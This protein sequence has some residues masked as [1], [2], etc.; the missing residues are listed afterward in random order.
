MTLTT[1]FR[2][3]YGNRLSL[4]S[5][6]CLCCLLICLAG[7]NPPKPAKKTGTGT[8]TKTTGAGE[9][10]PDCHS[11][12]DNAISMLE[13]DRLGISSSLEA[14]VS[15]L[16]DWTYRCCNF[17]EKPPRIT[18]SQKPFLKKYLSEAQLAKMDL[19]RFTE[20]DGTFIRDSQLFNGMV[21]AAIEGRKNDRERITAA[22]YYCMNN[23]DLVPDSKQALPFSPYEACII[24]SATAE[25]RAW[26][27]INLMRQL[28]LDAVLFRPAKP[29]PFKMLVGVFVGNEIY[30]FD[31]VLGLPVPSPAQP[32]DAV[33]I[34]IP[35]TY[36]EVQKTPDLLKKFYGKYSDS[37]FSAEE[38][39]A[40][41]VE[42]IGRSSEWSARMRRLEDSLSRKQ[43]FVLFRNLDPLEGDPGFIGHIQTIGKGILKD[44][45]ILVSE[46]PDQQMDK[47]ESVSGDEAKI[48]SFLKMPFKAPI[49]YEVS[50]KTP[51]AQGLYEAQWGPPTRKLLKTRTT[52]L[53]GNQKAAVKSYVTT[54]LEEHMPVDLAVAPEIRQMH[55]MAGQNAAY[56][57]GIGQFIQGEYA[58][59]SISLDAYLNHRGYVHRTKEG[60]WLAR[61]LSARY[62]R[63]I[64]DAETGKLS[65]AFVTLSEDEKFCPEAMK[66]AF[67]YYSERWK[68]IRDRNKK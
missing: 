7:C 30:L 39:K 26:I 50:A 44:A 46:Y 42:I 45:K 47:A 63:A 65:Y 68:A 23:I 56:F 33:Q 49:P 6:A 1:L 35:A 55:F 27:Y 31:P 5:G 3:S 14:A 17:D 38:L 61:S 8:G 13:P 36:A 52:Q 32:E 54:R 9:E 25:E 53:L 57:I 12:I 19:T 64:A 62:H 24:G 18:D 22:F 40:A 28:R 29:A 10:D 43:N 67:A 21:N 34:Q 58:T 2:Q 37:R 60:M 16:N 41:Q 20:Y 48:L 15:L 59:A 51:N 66:P 11:Y 4:L